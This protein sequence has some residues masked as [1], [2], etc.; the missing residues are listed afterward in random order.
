ERKGFC[1]GS[2]CQ[3]DFQCGEYWMCQ[4]VHTLGDGALI[5]TC[6]PPGLRRE[7]EACVR[8]LGRDEETCASGLRCNKGWCGRSC[9]ADEPTSCP[10]GFFCREGLNGPSC[11]PTCEAT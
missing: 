4:T 7:G 6:V 11:L 1:G 10:Q 8:T 5:R 2:T 3:A 9:Q